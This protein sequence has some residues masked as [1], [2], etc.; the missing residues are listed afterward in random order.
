MRGQRPGHRGGY[1]LVDVPAVDEERRFEG[2]T[3]IG[4]T[5]AA[6]P[7][8]R[9]RKQT[10]VTMIP[11]VHLVPVASEK[12]GAMVGGNTGASHF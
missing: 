9:P 8:H 2:R 4:V 10:P 5:Q 7:R 1:A 12:A 3:R 6:S 11:S